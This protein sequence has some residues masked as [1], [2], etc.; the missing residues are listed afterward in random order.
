MDHDFG[1]RANVDVGIS[2]N[3]LIVIFQ[4][5]VVEETSIQNGETSLCC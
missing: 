5:N 2:K 1:G 4:S 3:G